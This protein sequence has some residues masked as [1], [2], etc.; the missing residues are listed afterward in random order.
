[1]KLLDKYS[2]KPIG[3]SGGGQTLAAAISPHN[4]EIVFC[5]SDMG[6]IYR[7]VNGGKNFTLLNGH[8]VSRMCSDYNIT[9]VAFHPT[10]E[11]RVYIGVWNGLVMSDDNGETFEHIENYGMSCGPSRIDFDGE[12]IFFAYNDQGKDRTIVK[13]SDGDTL[14][15]VPKCSLGLAVKG[16]RIV[17]CVEDNVYVSRDSGKTVE[18]FLGGEFKGFY[19]RGHLVYVTTPKTLYCID[20]N[21]CVATEI[22]S[23]TKGSLGHV[24]VVD[25]RIYV[26]YFGSETQFDG[27]GISSVLLSTDGGLT[28]EPILFMHPKNPKWNV[29]TSWITGRWGWH[30]PPSC[31]AVTP[32]D[33][34]MLIY[35]NSTGMGITKDGGKTFFE[36]GAANDGSKIQVMTSWD[37][38]IDPND[39]N[40]HYIAM[41]DFSGWRSSDRG[42]TWEQRWIG[43]PWKSNV[44]CIAAHPTEKGRLIAGAANVHDLPYWH[45]M[46]RQNSGWNGGL[47]ESHDYGKTWAVQ[48]KIG[49][50]PYGVV[51]DV[52]YSKDKVYAAF[53]GGGAYVSDLDEIYWKPLDRDIKEKNTAKI[54][55]Y[56]DMVYIIVWPRQQQDSVIPGTVYYSNNGVDFEKF[57]MP[58]EIKYPVHVLPIS[59][60]EVYISCFDCI[61]YYIKGRMEYS[62]EYETFGKPGVYHT[63]DGGNTWECVCDIAAYSTS[64]IGEDIYICTK[65]NGLVVLKDGELLQDRSLPVFNPH[66]VT[67]DDEGSIYVTSFGQG[68]YKGTLK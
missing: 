37:Y 30:R 59:E 32:A 11:N 12:D 2:W 58:E 67:V 9:S 42:E 13:N 31:L 26:G 7:S 19:K 17:L 38:I 39:K 1:M 28:F 50:G 68:V 52:K 60:K 22:Y 56:G 16:E 8:V 46:R 51:T 57:P 3:P 15:E 48:D 5:A 44:Y 63:T 4:P 65:E 10:K 18:S 35:S 20:I 6:G 43:N 49:M 66:T 45:V 27:E 29:E 24:A 62:L 41:T 54:A 47:I 14:M 21:T 40:Q 25:D 36:A 53:F 23:V 61:D 55:V 34:K 64:K 33:P